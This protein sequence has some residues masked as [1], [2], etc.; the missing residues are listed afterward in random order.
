MGNSL[1]YNSKFSQKNGVFH[2][3]TQM[4]RIIAKA[5]TFASLC[6]AII[7]VFLYLVSVSTLQGMAR[8]T[9][10]HQNAIAIW[11]I[12]FIGLM[13]LYLIAFSVRALEKGWQ[14]FAA[15]SPEK[16]RVASIASLIGVAI[17]FSSLLV[18]TLFGPAVKVP[19]PPT[20]SV[21]SKQQPP[22]RP[23]SRVLLQIWTHVPPKSRP[24]NHVAISRP[25]WIKE[26][27]MGMAKIKKL[28]PRHY[29]IWMSND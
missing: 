1:A 8:E 2:A 13:T 7:L 11:A 23:A 25:F 15:R 21:T 14:H 5:F 24:S 16:A 19:P 22:P 10:L 18:D 3:V 17:I 6:F 28:G 29:Q 26:N 9:A 27:K 4:I 12:I 20:I